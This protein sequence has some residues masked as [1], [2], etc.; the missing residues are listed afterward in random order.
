MVVGDVVVVVD[1]GGEEMMGEDG[2]KAKQ[3]RLQFKKGLVT[4]MAKWQ[5]G[6][7]DID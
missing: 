3:M 7:D 1:D 4:D 6:H 5:I 2:K